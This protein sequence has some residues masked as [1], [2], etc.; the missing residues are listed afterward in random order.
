MIVFLTKK[1]FSIA[2]ATTVA[3]TSR[4]ATFL[5]VL[6]IGSLCQLYLGLTSTEKTNEKT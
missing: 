2:E 6:M 3:L 1:G 5:V 4:L